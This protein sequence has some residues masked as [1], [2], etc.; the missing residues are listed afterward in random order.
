MRM[1]SAEE[2]PQLRPTITFRKKESTSKK[3][4]ANDDD[5][6]S[7]AITRSGR[8]AKRVNITYHVPGKYA[9]YELSRLTHIEKAVKKT[10]IIV[11]YKVLL[12]IQMSEPPCILQL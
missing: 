2:E 3:D 5:Y 4:R 9:Y 7:S 6:N 8:R 10:T 11:I 1:S 12:Y